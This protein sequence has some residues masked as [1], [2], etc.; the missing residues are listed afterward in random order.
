VTL[1]TPAVQQCL[2]KAYNDLTEEDI[3]LLINTRFQYAIQGDLALN[4]V[5]P[6][7]EPLIEQT[8][9]NIAGKIMLNLY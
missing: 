7:Q 4:T 8:Q 3:I 5:G 1:R 2:Q 9:G 6:V